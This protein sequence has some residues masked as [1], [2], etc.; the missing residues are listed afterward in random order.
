MASGVELATA[1]VTV[2]PDGSKIAPEIR[3]QFG[4]AEPESK[5]FG[6]R[7]G[8]GISSG[9]G[10]S[11][12][13]V[14]GILAGAFAVDKVK[15]FVGGT[16]SA[17]SDLNETVSKSR[18]I[19]GKHAKDM[20]D[21]ADRADTSLGLSKQAAL[22]LTSSFADM[23]DQI[24]F[25]G[26][27]AAQMSV[28]VAGLSADLGSFNN[29]ETSDV[30]DRMSA[31]FRGEYDS[32]QALIPNI[33]AARV[34]SEALATTGKKTAKEL[35]AQEKAAAVL[36]IVSKDGAKAQGDFR[37][38]SGSLANQ[39]KILKAQF[40]NVQASIGQKLLP[41]AVKLANF[42]ND[43]LLPA[44][45]R[46]GSYLGEKL[47]PLVDRVRPVVEKMLSI[48]GSGGGAAGK[49]DQFKALF[50]DVVTTVTRLWELF[51]KNI[52]RFLSGTFDNIKAIL[53]GAFQI[54][55]GIFQVFSGVLKGDW[56]KVWT[57]IKN[58]FGGVVKVLV[59]MVKQLWNLIRFAF[60]NAGVVLKRIVGGIW[61]GV[62]ALFNNGISALLGAI[63]GLPGKIR[64]LGPLL[65][66][67]GKALL[68]AL[69][70]GLKGGAS[71]VGEIA[72]K[73]WDVV[74]GSL[75]WAIDKINAALEFTIGTPFGEIGI[76][77]KNIPHL[78]RG[79]DYHMGGMALVG[80]AGPEL[81]H[82]P[83]GTGVLS[84]RR[85]ADALGSG[86]A[87]PSAGEIG[88][89]V[90]AALHRM[91]LTLQIGQDTAGR[92]VLVGRNVIEQRA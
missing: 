10:S 54:I 56:S 74:K 18:V 16:I 27:E 79:T 84:A 44:L 71:F 23:F 62:K 60:S 72:G 17:A 28:Q 59:G 50:Q 61:G 67:A 88:A 1:Y 36:A 22:D 39:Q 70:N 35:T 55:R 46:F 52:V 92:V 7:A 82:M 3:K 14:G 47:P 51:G 90:A 81:I 77:P 91:G 4:A 78:A 86:D 30:A 2:I 57:G 29:L 76:N 80:E 68:D 58:I 24:G 32:L 15:D 85:T 64:A 63:R 48:F 40:E 5:R 11:L 8:K 26:T 75:N 19:F 6:Q 12:K 31:A 43:K 41:T 89:A 69:L 73:I 33:N 49:L 42:A 83:R 65:K 21:W 34:E 25:D 20:E 87:A 38:T 53:K 9:I 45:I 66:S 37:K 13:S